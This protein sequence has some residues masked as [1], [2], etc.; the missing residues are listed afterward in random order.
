MGPD[1]PTG[2]RLLKHAHILA[3]MRNFLLMQVTPKAQRS[4]LRRY[5]DAL[6]MG[7]IYG[8]HVAADAQVDRPGAQLTLG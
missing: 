3:A 1:S 8:I 2:L 5:P 6:M 4:L 7:T